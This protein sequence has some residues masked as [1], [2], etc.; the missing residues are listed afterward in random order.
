MS[1]RRNLP[2]ESKMGWIATIS[3]SK[4]ERWGRLSAQGA[5]EARSNSFL[6]FRAADWGIACNSQVASSPPNEGGCGE[7]SER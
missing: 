5:K 7:K 1:S 6:V 3:P 4:G 2:E